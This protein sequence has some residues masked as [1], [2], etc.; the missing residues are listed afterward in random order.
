MILKI[1]SYF[2]IIVLITSSASAGAQTLFENPEEQRTRWYSF[3]NLKATKGAGAM[4]NKGA[5]GH[6]ADRVPA[7]ETV[8]LLETEGPGMINRIW[9]T[10][11][12]RSPEML[13]SLRL[14]MFWDGEK[15]PAVS[16][17]LGDFFGIG[18]GRKVPFENALFSDPEG[19]S[20]NSIIPMP[21]KEGAR[22]T[23]TNDSDNDLTALF[24][25]INMVR[26]EFT[27][28]MLYFHTYWNREL[29]TELGEDFE[30]LPEVEGTGRFLGTNIGIFT[31]EDY[32]SSWWG[33]GEVKIFL[34]GDGESPTLVGT[35]TEDYIGTA[36]G[37]GT[38]NHQYQGA[39]IADGEKF[40]QAFYRYHIP[41]PVYFHD[42]I[43]VSIQQMGG[44]PTQK[45]R[46]LVEKGAK[47]EPVT[48]SVDHRLVKLLEMDVPPSLKDEDFPKGWTNFWRSD[49]VSATAYFYLDRPSSKLPELQPL[50]I[51]RAK[52]HE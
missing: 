17:P 22:I 36:W 43:R 10:I 34:D 47:L 19:R 6:P 23:I 33:E 31:N 51:R 35:G 7:G 39:L 16:V 46:D 41:D 45:V 48:V 26:K 32:S 24:F 14:E 52:L 28:D 29:S 13:R 25:D 42:D 44:W 9:L 30:I 3:E 38:F 18:L 12:D 11:N 27:E 2:I 8:I 40:E 21:F 50:K 37:Q 4:E 5:K 49:D 20:F 15:K 1:H